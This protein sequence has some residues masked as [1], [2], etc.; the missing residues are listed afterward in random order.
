[1]QQQPVTKPKKL[2]VR[3]D[4]PTKEVWEIEKKK[5]GPPPPKVVKVVKDIDRLMDLPDEKESSSE[6]ELE[7]NAKRFYQ[8]KLNKRKVAEIRKKLREERRNNNHR[9]IQLSA[10]RQN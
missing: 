4:D 1:M 2:F 7:M 5:I 3:A 10:P 8:K 9:K 6:D